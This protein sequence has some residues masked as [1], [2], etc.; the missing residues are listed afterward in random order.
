LYYLR[1]EVDSGG[2]DS[3]FRYTGGDT[4]ALAV[5][6]ARL[7][8]PQW[9]ALIEDAYRSLGSPYPLDIHSREQILDRLEKEQPDLLTRFDERKYALESEEPLDDKV[10]TFIWAHRSSFFV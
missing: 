7:L 9:S 6:G 5:E 4:A 1:Q 8:S 3:Y 10:D 2:F